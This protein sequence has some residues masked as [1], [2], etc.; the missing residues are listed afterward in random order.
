[1]NGDPLDVLRVLIE[2]QKQ[3]SFRPEHVASARDE[4]ALGILVAHWA[5]WD[6]ERI[7]QAFLAALEDA[8]YHDLRAQVV[9]LARA[10][11][12]EVE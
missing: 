3:R 8:N 6:G 7:A 11:G 9:E 5:G 1:M 2:E 12:L 10:A 4:D